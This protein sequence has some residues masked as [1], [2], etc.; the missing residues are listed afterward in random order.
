MSH[1]S[2]ALTTACSSGLGVFLWGFAAVALGQQLEVHSGGA[3]RQ[4]INENAGMRQAEPAWHYTP[5]ASPTS[6]TA[7]QPAPVQTAGYQTATAQSSELTAESRSS[8]VVST[9]NTPRHNTPLAPPTTHLEDQQ[10]ASGSVLQ[11]LISMMMSLCIVL[12]LFFGVLWVYR[13]TQRGGVN[14]SLPKQVVQV[15]GRTSLTSRQQLTVLRFGS[16]LL[17]VS[18]TQGEAKTLSEITDPHE[19]QQLIALCDPKTPTSRPALAFPNLRRQE[20]SA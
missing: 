19:A 6:Q 13:T 14:S 1:S 8:E 18:T 9:S 11:S 4:P 3:D 20:A 16:K 10:Q 5:P 15:V 17:L 2:N 12:G 7:A